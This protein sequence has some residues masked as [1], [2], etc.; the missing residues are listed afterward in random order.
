MELP[1]VGKFCTNPDCKQLD[2]L[3]IL[4]KCGQI[5]CKDHFRAHTNSCQPSKQL[6]EN[7]LKKID[8][9]LICSQNGC[10]ERSIV[11]LI[12]ERCHKHFCIKHRHLA[13]CENK[14]AETIAKE[15]EKYAE[16]VRKFAEAKAIV[17]KQLENNLNAVKKR[18][19]NIQM[20]N[21]VQLMKIKSKATGIKTIPV[22]DRIYFNVTYGV[23]TTPLFVSKQWSVGRVTDAIAQELKLQNNNN[24]GNEKKLRL[25]RN[26]D[27]QHLSNDMSVTLNRLLEEKSISDGENLLI[28][29]NDV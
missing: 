2:F 26:E 27:C 29:Y 21:K 24:K 9:I 17:D 10:S 8:N 3:P 25:F 28:Q 14:D 5:F 7:E 16:P 6:T 4:C 22:V 12:C 23:N 20:A 15:K 18:G 19:K 11:P 13:T 1:N